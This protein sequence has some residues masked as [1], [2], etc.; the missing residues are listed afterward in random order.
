MVCRK[1]LTS[2]KVGNCNGAFPDCY[3]PEPQWIKCSDSMPEHDTAV[4]VA[5]YGGKIVCMDAMYRNG[6]W[7]KSEGKD[8]T[9]WLPLPESPDMIEHH[10]EKYN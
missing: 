5:R 2:C 10:K 1:Y 7:Y 4:L 6:K 9:H 8:V 3:N